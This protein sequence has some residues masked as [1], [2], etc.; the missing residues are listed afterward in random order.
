MPFYFS[1]EFDSTHVFMWLIFQGNSSR[2][3]FRS[4]TDKGYSRFLLR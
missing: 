3:Y 4:G 1:V 2:S